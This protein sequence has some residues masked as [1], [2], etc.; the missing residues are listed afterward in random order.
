M[1]HTKRLVITLFVMALAAGCAS[2]PQTE[3]PVTEPETPGTDRTQTT[4]I[5]DVPTLNPEDHTRRDNLTN[6]DSL[7]SKRIV[8]F[9]YDS[10]RV[11]PEFMEIVRAHATYLGANSSAEVRLE[12]H[13]DER[14]T[15]EYNLGLGERRARSVMDMM[16]ARGS[17]RGQSDTISYGEERPVQT[18]S[19]E[20]CWSQNRRVEIVYSSN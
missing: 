6:P 9:D 19:S 17:S 11:R 3:E 14:G 8:Y 2:Q 4:P 5:R 16:V 10:S 18:C 1:Q 7:L 13:A 12:G 15:R 20:S